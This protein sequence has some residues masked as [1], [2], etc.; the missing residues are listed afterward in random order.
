M[1]L[2]LISKDVDIRISKIINDVTHVTPIKGQPEAQVKSPCKQNNLEDK[3]YPTEI[4]KESAPL[5]SS[6]QK[7]KY[8]G[9]KNKKISIKLGNGLFQCY[10]CEKQFES[11]TKS[12]PTTLKKH[13]HKT[14][15]DT[16]F[17]CNKCNFSS[18]NNFEVNNHCHNNCKKCNKDFDKKDSFK[19]HS[20]ANHQH[21]CDKCEYA[22]VYT[23]E[24]KLHMKIIHEGKE[25][26]YTCGI[27]NKQMMDLT[28]HLRIHQHANLISPINNTNPT[29]TINQIKETRYFKMQNGKF[30]C[31]KCEKQYT[32]K[33]DA[34]RHY[35][36][37]HMGMDNFCSFCPYVAYDEH[38]LKEHINI[39][40]SEKKFQCKCCGK[41]FQNELCYKVHI[42]KVHDIFCDKCEKSFVNLGQLGRHLNIDH[43]EAEF[44]CTHCSYASKDQYALR[45][46]LTRMHSRNDFKCE[47]CQMRFHQKN[48]QLSHVKKVHDH[49]CVSCPKVFHRKNQLDLHVKIDHEGKEKFHFCTICNKRYLNL[50][51]HFEAIHRSSKGKNRI[52]V[53][54]Y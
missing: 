4:H 47:F 45:T 42:S 19:H 16:V 27:C 46:H 28:Y 15:N 49:K 52:V 7:D 40:H 14:H 36:R 20:K 44:N 10:K 31:F 35:V 3:L 9:K 37:A 23:Y 32:T 1:E 34:G 43:K 29:N 18:R 21:F 38:R 48:D 51:S 5:L 53:R 54:Y 22:F 41:G 17:N 39:A 8:S 11:Q 24:L 30:K 33:S 25:K 50:D 26:Q 13:Y 6:A 12:V 2:A